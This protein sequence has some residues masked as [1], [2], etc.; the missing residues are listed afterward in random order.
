MNSQAERAFRVGGKLPVT[1]KTNY[2]LPPGVCGV[3][4]C[5]K[6]IQGAKPEEN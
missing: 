3:Q 5:G 4:L 6:L 1:I 2:S